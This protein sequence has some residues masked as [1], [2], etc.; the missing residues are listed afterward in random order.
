MEYFKI[1]KYY[2]IKQLGEGK[3]SKIYLSTNLKN[4]F[5]LKIIDY[6]N[7]K[8]E[9]EHLDKINN[10]SNNNCIYYIEYFKFE[11]YMIIIY[12]LMFLSL[13][14]LLEFYYPNGMP[15]EIVLKIYFDISKA[16]RYIHSK[17]IIHAD[18]KPENICVQIELTINNIHMLNTDILNIINSINNYKGNNK[19]KYIKSI[20]QDNIIEDSEDSDEIYTDSDIDSEDEYNMIYQYPDNM[21]INQIKNNYN[22]NDIFMKSTYYLCDFGNSFIQNN[23]NYYLDY[24]TRYYRAPEIIL[25]CKHTIKSDYWALGC[26][27]IELLH[28]KILFDPKR[29]NKS[30]TDFMHLSLILSCFGNDFNKDGRKYNYFFDN[31]ERLKI[32]YIIEP[33]KNKNL[34]EIK[35][36]QLK[37]I[38]DKLLK[39]NYYKRKLI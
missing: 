18:I 26:S 25:R 11:K 13:D 9:I 4:F 7:G 37:I 10:T 19:I 21:K 36:N 30:T 8:K 28:N 3:F 5:A 14:K 12:P 29:I 16:L 2:I 31:N 39:I 6:D 35:N 34:L 27:L 38:I 1:K 24:N 17:N 22:Y 32:N 33:F 23:D 20:H 15:E